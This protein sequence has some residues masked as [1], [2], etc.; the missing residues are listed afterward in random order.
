MLVSFSSGVYATQEDHLPA[1]TQAS[2]GQCKHYTKTKQVFFGDLHV[3]TRYSLDAS[4]Q[5]VRIS[6][7]DAYAFGRGEAISLP[8]YTSDGVS[9]R[10]SQLKRPIDFAAVTDHAEFL[11]EVLL[12]N[13]KGRPAYQNNLCQLL[14]KNPKA[15]FFLF[16]ST[17]LSSE[18]PERFGFCG[19]DG[20]NCLF[21]S[22]Y[23]WRDIRSA[24][25][26]YNDESSEC[27]FTT[28]VAY[29]WTGSP[30]G[31]NLHRNVV[32]ATPDVP[33]EPVSYVDASTPEELLNKLDSTCRVDEGCDYL[34]IPHNSNLSDGRMFMLPET[35]TRHDLK[36][37]AKRERL[38]EIIQHK[39]ASECYF[40]P[41]QVDEAC[42]FEALP[43][44]SFSGQF[45]VLL[46]DKPNPQSFVRHALKLGLGLQEKGLREN[47]NKE[48]S[49]NPFK[50]GFVGGTDTHFGKAGGVEEEGF[51][52][53]GG[54]GKFP[55]ENGLRVPDRI[56]Y[57]PGGLTGVWAEENSRARIFG[58]LK[59]R[60]SFA[61]SGPRIAPRVYWAPSPLPLLSTVDGLQRAQEGGTP[62]GQTL[63]VAKNA[64]TLHAT[65]HAAP[66]YGAEKG[67]N[68]AAIDV[69][70]IGSRNGL[71]LE[72]VSRVFERKSVTRPDLSSCL[73]PDVTLHDVFEQV[74][75][76]LPTDQ[77]DF[78]IYLRILEEPSCR[79]TQHLCVE[80]AIDC[81]N[82][83]RSDW[84][85]ACCSED[86]P[87][88]IQE[89]AWTSPVW[90]HRK[91]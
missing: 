52:G 86:V 69:I 23:P 3:H 84:K 56:E 74:E 33:R 66:D 71:V 7:A 90:V 58:A 82:E 10:R 35:T 62:M 20:A 26:T 85:H 29:E 76:P 72:R 48:E 79:W 6:P 13:Q 55:S 77:D 4:T 41:G 34:S 32:F 51:Q 45:S 36:L 50:L 43:Y 12:C 54:A 17:Y 53:H 18:H 25:Q 83:S 22:Y 21:A 39:G 73:T 61:T 16:N 91:P 80:N 44:Q 31:E 89:R 87:K 46:R 5:G 19:R 15:A 63:E 30:Q 60:E 27:T 70:R 81:S 67:R 28:F 9:T 47:T 49:P 65:V 57:S 11:G 68:I 42:E 14:R 59:R 88:T 75:I 78:A 24:A 37:R 64:K 8:P 2:T 1:P 40:Q 38:V